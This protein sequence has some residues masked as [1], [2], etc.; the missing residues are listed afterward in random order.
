MYTYIYIYIYICIYIYI[1]I[2]IHSIFRAR[3]ARTLASRQAARVQWTHP[4][5]ENS[6]D[7]KT[8][9]KT[10]TPEEGGL[11]QTPDFQIPSTR[12]GRAVLS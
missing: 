1:Y 12:I 2:Y 5:T 11:S 9:T 3:L 8:S 7:R 4:R 6:H 10:S